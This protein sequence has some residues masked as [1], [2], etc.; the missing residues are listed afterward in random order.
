MNR[1]ALALSLTLGSTAARAELPLTTLA[2]RSF[3]GQFIAHAPRLAGATVMPPDLVTNINALE[4]KPELLAVSAERIKQALWLELGAHADWR[5]TIHLNLRPA[6][7][8]TDIVDVRLERFKTTW[9][10]HVELPAV[11]ERQQYVRALVSVILLEVANRSAT[12]HAAEI[13]AWMTEG[14]TQRLLETRGKELMLPPPRALPGGFLF[15]PTVNEVR[16][17]DPMRIVRQQLKERAPLTIEE[18]SWPTGI[19]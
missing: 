10:Y 15:T 18:L 16:R 11:M 5:D 13:P 12:D 1:L 6:R 19:N 3:S 9:N 14:L 2:T 4:L 17:E 7:S 8:A